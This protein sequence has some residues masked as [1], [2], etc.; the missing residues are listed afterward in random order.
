MAP[1]SAQVERMALVA[2]TCTTS[3]VPSPTAEGPQPPH[4]P[5]RARLPQH[6]DMSTIR[7]Q[8]A[9]AIQLRRPARSE[10]RRSPPPSISTTICQ[11]YDASRTRNSVCER[12]GWLAQ[13]KPLA[14]A[15]AKPDGWDLRRIGGWGSIYEGGVARTTRVQRPTRGD[16]RRHRGHRL[17]GLR[18]AIDRHTSSEYNDP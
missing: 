5:T 12:P 10:K 15:D 16:L 11:H 2:T 6:R 7:H 17:G 9:R 18:Y 13:R 1:P 14:S 3:T 8:Y 4:C